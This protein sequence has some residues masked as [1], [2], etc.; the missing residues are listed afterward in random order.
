MLAESGHQVRSVVCGE[1]RF[2]AAP[3]Y[4]GRAT[5]SIEAAVSACAA[6]GRSAVVPED[7]V[8]HARGLGLP[9]GLVREVVDDLDAAGDVLDLAD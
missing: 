2:P 9:F 1:S 5:E 6:M 7:E 3:H 8:G 4:P